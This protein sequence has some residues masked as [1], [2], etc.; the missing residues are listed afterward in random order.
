[1]TGPITHRSDTGLQY[2]GLTMHVPPGIHEGALELLVAHLPP[3]ARILDLAAGSGAFTQR[4]FDAGYDVQAADLDLQGWS[5]QD[6]PIAQV[7]CNLEV[8]NLP[9]EDFEGIVAIELIEHLENPTLFIRTA[10]KHLRGGG[11]LLFTTPNVVSLHSRRRIL[12]TGEFAFFGRG[13]LFKAGHRTPLPFWLLEDLL[14]SEGYEIKQRRF[15]GHQGL[16]FR[17]G[18]PFWKVLIVPLL[19]LLFMIVGRKIPSEANL[20]STVAYVVHKPQ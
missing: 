10:A 5:I 6:V 11:F 8:W 18:R 2:Q 15:F 1:M 9:S 19:D 7:D 17:P 12:L 3:P 13:L 16:F 4:L 14:A 20:A